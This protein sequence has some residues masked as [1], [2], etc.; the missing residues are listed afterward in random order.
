M[1]TDIALPHGQYYTWNHSKLCIWYKFFSLTSN[2]LPPQAGE[3]RTGEIVVSA[4]LQRLASIRR[5]TLEP[6]ARGKAAA[7]WSAI[8]WFPS[9]RHSSKMR[10]WSDIGGSIARHPEI[11][12][13]LSMLKAELEWSIWPVDDSVDSIWF[14]WIFL[15]EQ[16]IQAWHPKPKKD[17]CHDSNRSPSMAAHI[18]LNIDAEHRNLCSV[19]TL[20]VVIW[21]FHLSMDASWSASRSLLGAAISSSYLGKRH[22]ALL[23]LKKKRKEKKKHD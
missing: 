11:W 8:S 9:R 7:S 3:S 23:L 21:H 15:P 18:S 22:T 4:E 14:L 20:E 2:I 19:P 5:S 6:F 1:K 12:G 13:Q 16:K 17:S 10:G